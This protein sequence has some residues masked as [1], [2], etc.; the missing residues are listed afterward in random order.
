MSLL[1][2]TVLDPL[3]EKTLI[4]QLSLKAGGKRSMKLLA[5]IFEAVAGAVML[6][7][8]DLTQTFSVLELMVKIEKE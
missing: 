7:S 3:T 2:Y 6:D 8:L 4:K 1:K 5:D